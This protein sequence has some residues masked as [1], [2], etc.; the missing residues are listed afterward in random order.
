MAPVKPEV[1]TTGKSRWNSL[2]IMPKTSARERQTQANRTYGTQ[3]LVE[4]LTGASFGSRSA[5][6]RQLGV[7]PTHITHL[8]KG[9]RQASEELI[10]RLVEQ[11]LG[12]D[13]QEFERE[14]RDWVNQ[15]KRHI[16]DDLS[17]SR[18]VAA[19]LAK[20]VPLLPEAITSV[21]AEPVPS[22]DRT[23]RAW[24]LRMISVDGDFR[25]TGQAAKPMKPIRRAK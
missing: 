24:L 12:K 2:R 9:D 4:H 3:L 11:V 6:A 8:A 16:G 10:S 21:V 5:L 23:T 19:R 22:P 14:A 17:E 20:Q 1:P 13:W 25:A 15:Q 7:T 18:A